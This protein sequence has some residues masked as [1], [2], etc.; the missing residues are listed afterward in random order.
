MRI[1]LQY[2]YQKLSRFY[3]RSERGIRCFSQKEF[4]ESSF[5]FILRYSLYLNLL[6][7]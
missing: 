4:L 3:S 1:G 5:P 6:G 2:H 7:P